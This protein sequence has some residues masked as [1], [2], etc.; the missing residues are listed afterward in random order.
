MSQQS[1]PFE[2]PGFGIDVV[3]GLKT[4]IARAAAAIHTQRQAGAHRV[5][6]SVVVDRYSDEELAA[7][8]WS[9]ADIRRLRSL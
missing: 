3:R 6:R 2:A 8:G 4:A 7:H 1:K 9:A 5:V